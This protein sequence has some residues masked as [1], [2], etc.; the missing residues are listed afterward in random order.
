VAVLQQNVGTADEV[1]VASANSALALQLEQARVRVAAAQREYERL[2]KI[3]DIAAGKDVAA[4]EA[5]LNAARAELSTL[6][7][8][9]VGANASANARTIPLVAP[10]AGVVGA[11]TLAVG[12]EVS[13]G[14]T[15]LTVT[16]ISK[17]YV[18]AQVYDR[19]LPSVQPGNKFSVT[20]ST[21][22]HKT[23]EVRLLSQAQMMNPGNQSQRVLFELDNPHGEFKI[24]EFVIL[25]ALNTQT[26]RQISVPNAAITEING[27]TAVFLKRGPEKFE[28]AYV[29]I[30]E[31]D[32][33]RTLVLKGIKE[34][35]KVVVGGAYEVKMMYLN[36]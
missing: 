25:K 21:D 36:M 12:A 27:K 4:A 3:E 23:A 34:G 11:F 5:G 14:Q 30:G 17:V 33:T 2:K 22:D 15:L 19:D 13:A 16:N 28:F 6:E 18:E 20:C 24:G 32:G 10:I 1:G 26:S 29:Q 9:A 8:K 7:G 35:E 31:D